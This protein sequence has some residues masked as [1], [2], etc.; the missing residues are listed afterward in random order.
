MNHW[1]AYPLG[2][3]LFGL[4]PMLGSFVLWSWLRRRQA[5]ARFGT[6]TTLETVL[7]IRRFPRFVRGL[8]GILGTLCLLVGI[9]GPQ[10]GR[11]W[12]QPTVPGRDLMVVL[13]CSRSMLAESPSR[14]ERARTFATELSEAIQAR[15]GH[16]LGLVVFAGRARLVCPL[17]HDYAYFRETLAD[18]DPRTF[19]LELAPGP[20]DESGTRIGAGLLL[21]I[22]SLEERFR[23]AR[24]V[25]LLSDGDDPL[26]DGEWKAGAAEAKTQGI[27]VLAVGFGDPNTAHTIPM[28]DSVQLD[29]T[30]QPVR[31]RLDEATLRE[32]ARLAQG[33]YVPAATNHRAA[34]PVYLDAIASLPVRESD[35]DALPIYQQRYAWFYLASLALLAIAFMVP[36]RLPRIRPLL[37]RLLAAMRK[38]RKEAALP[39]PVLATLVVVAFVFL[40]AAVV[41]DPQSL[42]KEGDAAA[43]SGDYARAAALYKKAEPLTTEPVEVAYRLGVVKYQMAAE[44][45][46]GANLFEAE[47]LFRCCLDKGSPHRPQALFGLGNCLLLKSKGKSLELVRAAIESYEQS[48]AA[49]LP[50]EVAAEARYNLERAKLLALQLL[51]PAT[52]KEVEP[53]DNPE[54]DAHRPADPRPNDPRPP[55]KTDGGMGTGNPDPR[56][57]PFQMKNDTGQT[58][59]QTSDP[60]PGVGKLTPIPDLSTPE[61][62]PPKDALSHLETATKRVLEE[63][64]TYRLQKLRPAVRGV[65]DW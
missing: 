13:D 44:A 51:A 58:P 14:F 65:R 64:Q 36:D 3:A 1:L 9:V 21:A 34:G 56:G 52:R 24:D 35:E 43:A 38:N 32:I 2:L 60:A 23:G 7:T 53:P 8:C 49:G 39:R 29:E 20:R 41:N 40:G 6:M 55:N 5:L 50:E 10:W 57:N 27:P 25:L 59:I 48:L 16:R 11:D 54:E 4:I 45:G 47:D 15:G 17:T 18:L 19:D 46:G 26:R 28:G 42:L 12:K 37:N 33:I 61:P 22:H 31:T 63:R 30:G 62:I